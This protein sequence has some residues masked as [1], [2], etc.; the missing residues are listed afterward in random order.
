MAKKKKAAKRKAVRK[1]KST[2]L[3]TYLKRKGE[4]LPH[5]YEVVVRK[6]PKKRKK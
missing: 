1:S 4:R 3:K 6:K 5:G 2:S